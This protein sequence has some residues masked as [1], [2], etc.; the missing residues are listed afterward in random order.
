MTSAEFAKLMGW[1]MAVCAVMIVVCLLRYRALG[2]S[3]Y[4]QAASFAIMG[5]LIFG[6]RHEWSAGWLFTFVGLL[7]ASFAADFVVRAR[8]DGPSEGA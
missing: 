8:R 2:A 7:L 4:V 6:V 5:V 3:A 1:G